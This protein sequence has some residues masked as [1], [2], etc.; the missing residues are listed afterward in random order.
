MP[1]TILWKKHEYQELHPPDAILYLHQLAKT[2]I[3]VDNVRTHATSV[4]T[5]FFVAVKLPFVQTQF[6]RET[7][8][9][10]LIKEQEIVFNV[11]KNQLKNIL[12]D[13]TFYKMFFQI[14]LLA[15]SWED[16][17]TRNFL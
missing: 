11:S 15:F 1:F 12:K 13:K 6:R 9:K 10:F 8:L 16:F 14:A 17:L 4:A 3:E 7:I 2:I 5:G